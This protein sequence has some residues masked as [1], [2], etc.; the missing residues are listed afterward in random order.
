MLVFATIL[1]SAIC[2]VLGVTSGPFLLVWVALGLS[3][4]GLALIV[5]PLLQRRLGDAESR[6]TDVAEG[7]GATASIDDD[8]AS[9][10]GGERAPDS[11]IV[12]SASVEDRS[13]P[14]AA[15]DAVDGRDVPEAPSGPSAPRAVEAVSAPSDSDSHEPARDSPVDASASIGAGSP[16]VVVPGRRRF[17]QPECHLVASRNTETVQVEEAVEEGF[18]ACS[19]CIPDRAAITAE[20]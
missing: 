8:G 14:S 15:T 19:T 17:H 6:A 16:V 7:S 12:A 5:T 13:E 2:L 18:S 20:G 10:I 9:S 1:A 3:V 4:A 11:E